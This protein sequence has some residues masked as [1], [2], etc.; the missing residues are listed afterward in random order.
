MKTAFVTD[1]TCLTPPRCRGVAMVMVM[2]ALTVATII[3]LSFLSSQTTSTAIAHNAARQVQA[4]AITEDG[5]RLAIEHLRA[6]PDW[7]DGYTHGLW[8]SWEPISDGEFRVMFEDQEDNDLGDDVSHSFMVTVEGRFGG[9]VHRVENLLTPEA[10]GQAIT[11]MFVARNE[12]AD[13]E[14]VQRIAA[15]ESWGYTVI[16]VADN[17]S[18]AVY[19]AAAAQSNVIY[20][21]EE[22]SSSSVD[23]RLNGFP[24]GVVN[25]EQ[26][27]QANLQMTH[28]GG[29][30]TGDTI[31]IIDNTHPITTG[32][33]AGQVTI[34]SQPTGLIFAVA[35][36][37]PGLRS[38][39]KR[40]TSTTSVLTL[41]DIGDEL[42]DGSPSPQ[43]RVTL[44]WGSNDFDFAELNADG[45]RL[46]RQAIEWAAASA[47]SA[48]AA[49]YYWPLNEDAGTTAAASVGGIDAEYRGGPLLGQPGIRGFAPTFTRNNDDRVVLPAEAMDG[50]DDY[51]LS[52]WF[53][54]PRWDGQSLV[55]GYTPSNDN[56]QLIRFQP[57]NHV[58]YS[59]GQARFSTMQ[60][61]IP[62]TLDDDEWHQ[63][64][65]VRSGTEGRAELYLDGES[66]G[67]VTGTLPT[68]DLD[69]LVLAEE[70]DQPDGGFIGFEAYSGSLD[71]VKIFGRTLS[72]TEVLADYESVLTEANSPQLTVLY[73][74]NEPDLVAPNLVGHWEFEEVV[75]DRGQITFGGNLNMRDNAVVDSYNSAAGTYAQTASSDAVMVTN[76][77]DKFNVILDQSSE[78]RGDLYIGPG[79][80]PSNVVF[81]RPGASITG[82]T[83]PLDLPAE[84]QSYSPPFPPGGQPLLIQN[85]GGTVVMSGDYHVSRWQVRNG[86]DIVI[87]G[88]V[89]MTV[90]TF[91]AF[92]DGSVTIPEGSSLT[93]YCVNLITV[94]A[95]FMLNADDRAAD[96]LRIFAH[97]SSSSSSSVRM[98]GDSVTAAVIYAAQ[99]VSISD[100][101]VFYG[102]AAAGGKVL[103]HD[104]SRMHLDRGLH[105]PSHLR[106]A[107]DTVTP[108]YGVYRNGAA[109]EADASA[110]ISGAVMVADG[111]DDFVEVAHDDAYLLDEGTVSCWFKL[112]GLAG[113]QGLITKDATGVGTGGHLALL[114]DGN[115]L[116]ASMEDT[117]GSHDLTGG[118]LV[119]GQWHHAALGFG[120]DGLRLYLDGVLV[121]SDPYAGGMGES[122]GGTGNQE[123]WAFGVGLSNSQALST[124]G[125]DQPFGGDLDDVRIYD[126]N[127]N[128]EQAGDLFAKGPPRAATPPVVRD[129]AGIGTPLDMVIADSD[130]VTWISGGGLEIDTGTV[131]ATP[132][133]A[134]RLYNTLNESQALT[135]EVE[136]TPARTSTG[137]DETIFSLSSDSKLNHHNFKL[138][139]QDD[140]YLAG[141]RT[142]FQPSHGNYE[143]SDPVFATGQREHVIFTLIDE[144]L[145]VYRNGQLEHTVSSPGDLSTWESDYRLA[146]GS[147]LDITRPWLGT[148]HRV[149]VWDEAVNLIQVQNLFNG[150]SPGPADGGGTGFGYRA[151]WLEKP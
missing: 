77:V 146:L 107:H 134:T 84:I 51:T 2:I 20:V 80:D 22:V 133:P 131:I 93:L 41:V 4:R 115:R 142:E 12:P 104:S 110:P 48:P 26:G 60:W 18:T 56:T 149:A 40:S 103:V 72:A 16:T 147:R 126:Q 45:R 143:F 120:A 100:N 9:V 36:H 15:M 118:T 81:V 23:D 39:A 65:L 55:S 90:D 61:T 91:T 21:S 88:D 105:M 139:Q 127:L 109:P 46:M 96:R 87:S 116:S 86:T 17:A 79:G 112:D 76:V 19:E 145:R 69:Q 27:L 78:I 67:V 97:D 73:E 54:T 151:E 117:S 135:V 44:P 128:A 85:S 101:A 25:E 148:L 63:L 62:E 11:V 119:A 10:Q 132:G 37:A 92:L 53:K 75:A 33:T 24:I 144:E 74:F 68:V 125:W 99:S 52:L 102:T 113:T 95:G 136:F 7:R 34:T 30:Y 50:R 43:R 71:E 31:E 114:A 83:Q 35:P 1:T 5:L 70:Q 140:T 111:V 122:S 14:D 82:D 123:P 66:Q 89:T 58:I 32:F 98:R 3:T 64:V 121:A 106:F 47:S 57:G 59:T 49:D 137:Q 129:T 94:D 38:L 124:T 29:I 42:D 141:V 28:G 130:H 150:A 6:T 13:P 8:S 108:R 138:V